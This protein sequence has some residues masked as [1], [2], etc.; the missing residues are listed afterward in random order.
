MRTS[1]SLQAK[2]FSRDCCINNTHVL[3]TQFQK[4]RVASDPLELALEVWKERVVLGTGWAMGVQ[5]PPFTHNLNNKHGFEEVGEYE[6]D[7]DDYG[8]LHKEERIISGNYAWKFMVRWE[9]SGSATQAPDEARKPVKGTGKERPR[10]DMEE[11]VAVPKLEKGKGKEQQLPGEGNYPA[12]GKLS[13]YDAEQTRIW[14][15]VEQRLDDIRL[16]WGACSRPN[17]TLESESL[18]L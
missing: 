15:K 18:I 13:G 17:P 2:Q 14:E 16:R 7:L 4:P 8:F 1:S 3:L 6:V 10:E 11:H 5:A 12:P 9:A